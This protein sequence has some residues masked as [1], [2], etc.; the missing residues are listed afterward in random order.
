MAT[1]Q[2]GR[3]LFVTGKAA[4]DLDRFRGSE[5]IFP[6][7]QVENLPNRKGA[8]IFGEHKTRYMGPNTGH[9][10]RN[11]RSDRYDER[12]TGGRGNCSC[13]SSCG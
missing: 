5:S 7:R 4:A 11:T 1:S 9:K 10:A 12:K 3:A 8:D 13:Q 6:S 2:H